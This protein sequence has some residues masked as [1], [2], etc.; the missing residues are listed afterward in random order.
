VA[1]NTGSSACDLC[2][3]GGL[4]QPDEGGSKCRTCEVTQYLV[5]G[6]I[7]GTGT[8]PPCPALATCA[9]GYPEVQPGAFLMTQ[10]DGTLVVFE[11]GS[12]DAC[13]GG[14]C[15]LDTSGNTNVSTCCAADRDPIDNPLCGR[16][17][18]GLSVD[19]NDCIG[20]LHHISSISFI[21]CPSII[22]CQYYHLRGFIWIFALQNVTRRQAVAYLD[23]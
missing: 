11:C 4:Y 20:I 19:G 21:C 9:S 8:C 6:S 15:S 7:E 22:V 18:P 13:L 16:C 1:A 17:K 12:S 14:A 23:C 3:T 5:R 2:N 10:S